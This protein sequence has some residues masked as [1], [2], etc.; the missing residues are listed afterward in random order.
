MRISEPRVNLTF[1][2]HV[3]KVYE[4]KRETIAIHKIVL[5]LLEF[6][7]KVDST[8]YY[9]ESIKLKYLI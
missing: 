7:F 3:N 1:I 2:N 8:F 5:T 4:F 9:K 6:N